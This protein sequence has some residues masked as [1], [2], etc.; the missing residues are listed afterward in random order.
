MTL[1]RPFSPFARERERGEIAFPT[2]TAP[3]LAGVAGGGGGSYQ[4]ILY[5]IIGSDC[6]EIR[7]RWEKGR[8]RLSRA[9]RTVGVA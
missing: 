5:A 9:Q 8:V 1:F 7:S 2:R 3:E 4:T 6:G